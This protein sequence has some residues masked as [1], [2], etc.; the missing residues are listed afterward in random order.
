[1]VTYDSRMILLSMTFPFEFCH[2]DFSDIYESSY[3]KNAGS[4]K[5]MAI[6]HTS[7]C[8]VQLEL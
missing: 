3:N 8:K 5:V 4:G 1:L 7:T 6:A 2:Q